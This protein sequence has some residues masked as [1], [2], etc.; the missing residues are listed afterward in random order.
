V[1]MSIKFSCEHC[2]REVNA[3]DQAAG[4]RGKCPYC[5]QSSYIP[6]P[7]S[8][9]DVLDLAPIDEDEERK[10]KAEIE[11]LRQAEH[12]LIAEQ[13]GSDEPPLEQR[14]DV[15]S[16]DLHHFVVNYCLDMFAGKLDRARMHAD[17]L[18]T[19]GPA[20]RQAIRD[21]QS[22]KV[23]EDALADIPKP[24]LLGFLKELNQY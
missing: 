11:A 5:G 21:F 4:K 9:E 6:A 2:H 23:T 18:R 10:R 14:D 17:K 8:D 22:G 7:V 15:Q 16:D 20:G 3:P 1:N 13:R 12:D 19:F 24:V